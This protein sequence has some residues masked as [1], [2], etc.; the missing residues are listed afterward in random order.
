M[1]TAVAE[2]MAFPDWFGHNLDALFDSLTDLSW[3]PAGEHVLVWSHPEVLA[4][5]DPVGYRGIRS[6]LDDAV[7]ATQDSD[8][9]VTVR[10]EG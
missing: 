4:G 8:R 7:E 10:L 9:K 5:A 1:L 3:L 6:V 2:A